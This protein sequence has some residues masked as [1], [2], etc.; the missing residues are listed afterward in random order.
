[1]DS[2]QHVRPRPRAGTCTFVML[3]MLVTMAATLLT[4]DEASASRYRW[5][6]DK[7][8]DWTAAAN[9]VNSDNDPDGY[10]NDP[11]DVV[12]IGTLGTA[13]RFITIPENVTITIRQI[14]FTASQ[15]YGIS[16][17]GSGNSL[18]KLVFSGGS[19]GKAEIAM[20]SA[21]ELSILAPVRLD[22]SLSVYV[23]VGGR[24]GFSGIRCS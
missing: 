18:G 23:G 1:M 10:P 6:F 4:A 5:K 12:T 15:Y 2:S 17:N 20:L 14:T 24:V 21:G 11:D 22:S 7:E 3:T 13:S 8:G 19:A 16:S 9:W